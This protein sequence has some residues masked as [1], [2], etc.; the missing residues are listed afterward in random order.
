M[1]EKIGVVILNWN[2]WDM[3]LSTI[4]SLRQT[5]NLDAN[6]PICVVDNGSTD[7][8][9]PHLRLEQGIDL[10]ELSENHGFAAGNNVGIRRA[11]AAGCTIILLLNNDVILDPDF[12]EPSLK[13]LAQNPKALVVSPKIHFAEPPERIWYAGGNFRYPRL[14]GENGWAGSRRQR[15]I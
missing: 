4:K 12:L 9:V 1:G 8:S 2:G 6:W 15:P 3:T 13:R 5:N 7:D 14:I 11:L 10:I